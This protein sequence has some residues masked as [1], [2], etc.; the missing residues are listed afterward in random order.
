MGRETPPGDGKE[1]APVES[2]QI[3]KKGRRG[4]EG[5]RNRILSIA[6]SIF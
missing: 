6:S 1:M 3:G 4:G 5:R 2:D